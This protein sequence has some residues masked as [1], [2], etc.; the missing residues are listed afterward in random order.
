MT[1]FCNMA[2]TLTLILLNIFPENKILFQT[3][4]YYNF[5][6]VIWAL[7]QMRSSLV[8]HSLDKF[9]I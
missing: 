8:F 4:F 5:G 7:I 2:N 1:D 9:F 6:P 3:C